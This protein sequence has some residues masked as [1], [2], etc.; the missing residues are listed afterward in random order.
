MRT[1][2]DRFLLEDIRTRITRHLLEEE[3]SAAR[4]RRSSRPRRPSASRFA[5]TVTAGTPVSRRIVRYI[6][7]RAFDAD[8]LDEVIQTAGTR[9]RRV[10]E[11]RT[12]RR[13]DSGVLS[14]RGLSRSATVTADRAARRRRTQACSTVTIIEGPRFRVASLTLPGV[15]PRDQP[16]VA[17][18]VRLD[19]GVP[20]VTAELDAAAERV[21]QVLRRAGLQ[22]AS[23]S[24]SRT[25][26]HD[27]DRDGRHHVRGARR[28]AADPARGVDRRRRRGPAKA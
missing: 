10:A 25:T 13:G 15:S 24:R 21:E 19:S 17:A 26:P 6:G 5:S 7:A 3:S 16:A 8:R 4:S 20:F 27:D 28:A 12:A 11:P 14:R 22:R 1:I 9:H 23:S 18:A 2:F